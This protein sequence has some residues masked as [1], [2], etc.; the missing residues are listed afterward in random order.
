VHELVAPIISDDTAVGDE[1]RERVA[2]RRGA[3]L[4]E[5][6]N[7][8]LRHR[9]RGLDEDLLNALDGCQSRRARLG[10][11]VILDAESE[12][13]ALCMQDKTDA[14]GRAGRAML[15]GEREIVFT[16]APHVQIR[17]SPC[18][19]LGAAPQCLTGAHVRGPLARMVHQHNSDLVTPLQAAQ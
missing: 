2:H 8:T 19:K 11:D 18:V 1:R 3:D 7:L 17:V 16:A 6:A 10:H 9:R 14:A 15:D 5:I 13:V 4:G 12:R